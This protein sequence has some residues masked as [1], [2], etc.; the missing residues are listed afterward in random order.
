VSLTSQLPK[1]TTEQLK[2]LADAMLDASLA[3]ESGQNWRPILLRA[4][5]RKV[6]LMRRIYDMLL[7]ERD[8][9]TVSKIL[10][11]L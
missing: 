7:Q 4:R 5:S 2:S 8:F 1:L 11:D 3:Y 9:E 6:G 10:G